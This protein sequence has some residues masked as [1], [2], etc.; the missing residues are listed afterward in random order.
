MRKDKILKYLASME[1]QLL[2]KSSERTI[3]LTRAWTKTFP[4][5]AGVYL[6]RE[7]G[8]ISY[9]GETGSIRGRMSDFLNTRNHVIRKNIGHANFSDHINFTKASSKVK[10][11]DS[12]EVLV[13]EWMK[14]NLK[15]SVL[16]VEFGRKELEEYICLNH[17][18]KYN[19]KGKRL[20]KMTKDEK[21]SET[22]KNAEWGDERIAILGWGSLQWDPRELKTKGE[23]HLDGPSL[24]IEFARISRD[25]R[26]TLVI[27]PGFGKVQTLYIES[28]FN[29]LSEARTN[30][31]AREGAKADSIGYMN[32]VTGNC[33]IKRVSEEIKQELIS[34]NKEKKF[35]AVIWTDLGPNFLDST[36]LGFNLDNIKTY[37]T[38]LSPEN[39]EKAKEYILRAPK[40]IKTQFRKDLTDF[41]N[42][43][44]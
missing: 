39:Y 21:F 44:K 43:Y 20:S 7:N 31:Q 15:V 42:S 29:S 16:P 10:F 22:I 2:S 12:I 40:Q 5:D 34:W 23:W 19:N 18:P 13:E 3:E 9:V 1:K 32:F 25:K 36:K 33:S 27:K 30:L 26:L 11:H 41:L 37:L 6:L 38:T 17:K 4:I 28:G 8:I 35:D 24:P 14:S